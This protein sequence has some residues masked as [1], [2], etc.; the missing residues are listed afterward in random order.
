MINRRLADISNPIYFAKCRGADLHSVESDINLLS[1][2]LADVQFF[3]NNL[4]PGGRYWICCVHSR[5]SVHR[6]RTAAI[7]TN[8]Y[9]DYASA[10]AA[11][12]TK[13]GYTFKFDEVEILARGDNRVSRE[14]LESWFTGP[15]SIF[16]AET[17]FGHSKSPLE[18]R[19][20]HRVILRQHRIA[21]QSSRPTP[22]RVMKVQQVKARMPFKK[23]STL[24]KA[25]AV[26]CCCMFAMAALALT[27]AHC[28]KLTCVSSY[29]EVKQA[30]G[31]LASLS[32]RHLEEERTVRVCVV[33]GDS[34]LNSVLRAYVE[35]VGSKPETVA[36]AFRFYMVP[37]SGLYVAFSATVGTEVCRR[38]SSLTHQ[39]RQTG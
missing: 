6:K 36:A 30:M 28:V 11:H 18:E 14:L 23:L 22:P 27:Q 32:H 35:Q 34:L 13:A 19:T 20:A 5:S 4:E 39:S 26:N 37:V 3:V 8:Q 16:G 2:P 17:Q 29:A 38:F 21:E 33:G 9:V 15:Q 7:S 12:S 10:V 25:I 31:Q 1:G 24:K